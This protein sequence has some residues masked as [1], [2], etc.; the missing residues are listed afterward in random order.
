MQC[1]RCERCSKYWIEGFNQC[2]C[3]TAPALTYEQAL[4][5]IAELEVRIA[6][7]I[8]AGDAMYTHG[9]FTRSYFSVAS[10]WSKLTTSLPQPPE[11]SV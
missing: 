5:R 4:A 10:D 3:P 11:R 1:E 8:E 7:L 9:D 2:D 6:K